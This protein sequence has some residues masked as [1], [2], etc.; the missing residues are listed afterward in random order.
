MSNAAFG[1][2]QDKLETFTRSLEPDE[3]DAFALMLAAAAE[4]LGRDGRADVTGFAAGPADVGGLGDIG[5]L[6]SMRPQSE[7]EARSKAVD[8][9]TNLLGKMSTTSD[10][11]TQNLK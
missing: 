4:A 1:R 10:G 2:L 5:M 11:I 7:L 8:L 9:L 3:L 6:A